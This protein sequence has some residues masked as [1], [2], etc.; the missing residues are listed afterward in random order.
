MLLIFWQTE[1]DRN[2]RQSKD[3]WFLRLSGSG[4]VEDFE[5][6]V[7]YPPYIQFMKPKG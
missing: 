1:G 5:S 4:D 6:L 7:D 2:H 3:R